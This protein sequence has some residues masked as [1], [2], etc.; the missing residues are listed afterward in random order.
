MCSLDSPFKLSLQIYEKIPKASGLNF[1]IATFSRTVCENELATATQFIL[2]F[3]RQSTYYRVTRMIC[4]KCRW[5]NS[6]LDEPSNWC[7]EKTMWKRSVWLSRR[8]LDS[9]LSLPLESSS[10]C[11][12]VELVTHYHNY[13][14]NNLLFNKLIIYYYLIIYSHIDNLFCNFKLSSGHF[15]WNF[16]EKNHVRKTR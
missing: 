5:K 14:W 2:R 16:F 15:L 11:T 3:S 10:L 1:N 8:I 13:L 9:K 6:L 4:T 7:I 12:E